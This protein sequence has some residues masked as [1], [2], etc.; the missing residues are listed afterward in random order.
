MKTHAPPEPQ[1]KNNG[2]E[3]SAPR[4]TPDHK[5]KRMKKQAKDERARQRV[6]NDAVLTR[7]IFQ[8]SR[9]FL[10]QK[11]NYKRNRLRINIWK[12]ICQVDDGWS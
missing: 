5:Q 1:K 2:K 10:V 7:A 3:G 4:P 9:L 6:N 8:K 12:S 11:S